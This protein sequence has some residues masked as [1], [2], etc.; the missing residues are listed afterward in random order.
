MDSH[1]SPKASYDGQEVRTLKIEEDG[2]YFRGRIKPKIRL[3]GRWLE[4]AGFKPGTRVSVKCLGSG[5][6]ELRSV[7]SQMNE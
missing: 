1:E 5:V 3:T 6:I 7:I 2:D 4:R